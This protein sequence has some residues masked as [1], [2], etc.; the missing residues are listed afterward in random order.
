MM[1][2]NKNKN[3][4]KNQNNN[5]KNAANNNAAKGSNQFKA[6][7]HTINALHSKLQN[8]NFNEELLPTDPNDDLY[9]KNN[10]DAF[11][12]RISEFMTHANALQIQEGIKGNGILSMVRNLLGDNDVGNKNMGILT[13]AGYGEYGKIFKSND[14]K[15]WEHMNRNDSEGYLYFCIANIICSVLMKSDESDKDV[16]AKIVKGKVNGQEVDDTGK[17]IETNNNNNK[18]S[19]PIQKN[20]IAIPGISPDSFINEIYKYIRG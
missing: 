11:N 3:Q 2:D 18:E 16:N 7:K 10:L 6:V 15:Y 4:N 5:G 19:V 13:K 20:S 1:N 9:A 8:L 14:N 12:I 17:A